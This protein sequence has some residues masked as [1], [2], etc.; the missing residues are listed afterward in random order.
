MC[1]WEK[2]EKKHKQMGLN[3][4]KESCTVKKTINTMKRQS[5]KWEKIV[6]NDTSDKGVIYKI[7]KEAIDLYTKKQSN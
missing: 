5:I 6:T 4:T 3:Q 1:I 7:Y 2:Q